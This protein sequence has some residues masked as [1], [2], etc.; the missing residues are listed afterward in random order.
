[1]NQV[2]LILLALGWVVSLILMV[3]LLRSGKGVAEKIG[4]CALLLVPFF[5]PLLY[6]FVV[7]PPPAKHPLLQAR[8]PRGEYAHKWIAVRPVLE[9]GLKQKGEP[10]EAAKGELDGGGSRGS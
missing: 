8:G 7:D 1:M 3:R 10:E 2:M 6:Q 9:D 4:G 5:G